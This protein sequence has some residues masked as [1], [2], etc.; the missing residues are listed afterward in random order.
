M[1]IKPH[2]NSHFRIFNYS[3]INLD[4][5]SQKL[6]YVM[7]QKMISIY[8]II[9]KKLYLDYFCQKKVIILF[10]MYILNILKHLSLCFNR[11][12]C[13]SVNVRQKLVVLF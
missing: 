3:L 4:K 13:E 1:H 2:S 11:K 7:L 12:C 9:I 6:N 5:F 10:E 8:K